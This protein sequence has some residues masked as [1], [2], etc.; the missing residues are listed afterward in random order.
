MTANDITK[1]D[2]SIKSRPSRFKFVKKVDA[3]SEEIRMRI[4]KDQK[5][6]TK[7]KGWSLDK[8]FSLVK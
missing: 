6:V 1:V 3:P 7:T 4:L 5:L 2:S 8:V